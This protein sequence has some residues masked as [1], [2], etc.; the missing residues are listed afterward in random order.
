MTIWR[1]Q[2]V[3]FTGTSTGTALA[4]AGVPLLF[5]VGGV[6]TVGGDVNGVNAL[7]A[8]FRIYNREW[9]QPDVDYAYNVKTRWDYYADVSIK[10]WELP[11]T[12][13]PPVVT[14]LSRLALMGAG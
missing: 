12:P 5:Q 14:F 1:D 8:D 3:V 7:W 13:T 9:K 6:Q 10:P 4:A 2:T 11:L